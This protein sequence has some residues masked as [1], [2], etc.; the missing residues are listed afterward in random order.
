MKVR[1]VALFVA[2]VALA[3][4]LFASPMKAGKWKVTMETKMAGMDMKLPPMTFEKCV[5]PEEAEKPQPPKMRNDDCK[6]EDYKLDGSTVTYK[7]KC[8]KSGT[9]GE[10]KI[11]YSADSYDGE[12]H[13]TVHGTEMTVKHTG[14]R[15]GDCDK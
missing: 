5:T 11:T 2:A 8:E 10:G 13:M 4:P 14:K 3:M 9:T 6:L 7:I 12:V 1:N 15:T